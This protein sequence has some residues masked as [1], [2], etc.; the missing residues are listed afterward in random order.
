MKKGTKF[1][2]LGGLFLTI[3][4]ML[5]VF[6]G[7]IIGGRDNIARMMEN[8]D[9]TVKV[10]GINLFRF[11]TD[12]D[13]DHMMDAIENSDSIVVS[14]EELVE[15]AKA[16]EVRSIRIKIGGG[17][18]KIEESELYDSFTLKY[19]YQK[20]PYTW[21]VSD[22]RLTIENSD[23]VLYKDGIRIDKNW[24]EVILYMP[25]GT[26]LETLEIDLG[27]G[28]MRL[29][30]MKAV[31]TIVSVGAGELVMNNLVSEDLNVDIGAGEIETGNSK[32]DNLYI[33]MSMGS[34]KYKGELNR[35]GEIHCSMG[36]VAL[37]LT[38]KRDD[39]NYSVSCSAGTVEIEDSEFTGLGV[40]KRIDNGAQKEIT[41]N[42]SMGSVEIDF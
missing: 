28:E 15:L 33:N 36:E 18:I 3:A 38:G 22:G 25:K 5:L 10:N 31:Q 35:N 6:T 13:W 17:S 41:I 19:K 40:A 37:D 26:S 30:N 27:G 24:D 42:C 21:N 12:Y 7:V 23:N 20:K 4:G 14:S 9:F 2:L 34:V 32:V 8:G 11:D 1:L 29:E 16:G 39:F